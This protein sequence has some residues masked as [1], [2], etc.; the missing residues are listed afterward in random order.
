M[1]NN[2]KNISPPPYTPPP[3]LSPSRTASGLY[4]WH[5]LSGNSGN[6]STSGGHGNNN[7][8]TSGPKAF[9][10]PRRSLIDSS[11]N[12]EE[13]ATPT[14]AYEPTYEVEVPETDIQPH[15]NVGVAYQARIPAYS[16]ERDNLKRKKDKADLMWSPIKKKSKNNNHYVDKDMDVEVSLAFFR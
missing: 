1:S 13:V 3:M 16:Q 4:Y 10:Y 12:K 15:V 5:I 2:S 14:T 9:T 11:T 8:S 6:N 7:N